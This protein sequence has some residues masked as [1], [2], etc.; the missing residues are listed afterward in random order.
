MIAPV[1]SGDHDVRRAGDRLRSASTTDCAWLMKPGLP[2]VGRRS[3]TPAVAGQLSAT[4]APAGPRCRGSARRTGPARP[5]R[6]RPGR[7][8]TISELHGEHPAGQRPP[9]QPHAS[10]HLAV[11]ASIMPASAGSATWREHNEHNGV[12][13][14]NGDTAIRRPRT[15]T[16]HGPPARDQGDSRAKHGPGS[17]V[18]R[19]P[20]ARRRWPPACGV[21]ADDD[22]GRRRPT[23]AGHG[24][25][26][27]GA[28]L[29][30]QRLRHH[31]P[32]RGQGDA[33]RQAHR[34]ASRCSTSP[35]PAA[36][37][38][39]SGSST[40]RAT[41]TSSC[42]WASA[43]SAAVYTNKS[44]ATL[45]RHHPDRPAH[46]GGRGDR[47]A[48][49]L[50]V[51]RPRPAGRRLEGRP[52]QG[53]GR[54]RAP[55]PGGPD[56]LTPML[57]AK[58]VGVDAEGRQLR[59]LR[60]RRR[61]ARRRCSASKV[62]FAATGVGEVAEQAKA[63]DVQILAVTSA[64]ARSRASTRRRSR[65]R[66]RPGVHQL[67]RHRRPARAVD[68]KRGSSS[69]G[70]ARPSMH[71]SDG[72]E[73]DAGRQG[74]DRRVPDRRRVRGVPD[75]GERAGRR[76]AAGAGLLA[77]EH[78]DHDAPLEQGRSELGV[79]LLL[80][81]PRRLVRGRRA[82]ARHGR[83]TPAGPGRPAGRC[84]WWSGAAAGRCAVLL[85]RRRPARRAR[86]AGGRRGRR[87][88]APAA[89]GARCGLL[90]GAFVANA[91]LIE[92]LGWPISGAVLFFGAAYALGSR[93]L[94]PRR[95]DR[96][97]AVASAPGTCSTL[98]LG[99]DLPGGLL[100]GIL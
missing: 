83:S 30:R 46:R 70:A 88:G 67:A 14:R 5:R 21:S 66:R 57:L 81:A 15:L 100:K 89:T 65:S 29:P 69:I 43:S 71:D 82:P 41:T 4:A 61:A 54:R 73:G 74:L 62:A 48:E 92:R 64:R 80:G 18:R 36:P 49:G 6:R 55:T 68:A 47:R 90:A 27:P 87:P 59:R 37:S 79:A 94:D 31:R 9:G 3:R 42:R 44:K 25:A 1:R 95:A 34:H 32:R 63:G 84:R 91:L 16:A 10:R 26:H 86:R 96:R 53:A 35:A 39:C 23:A 2:V 40:R 33:G 58:A 17:P 98:G 60:R 78:L 99:I 72:V 13:A 19:R 22:A 93:H 28:Q 20:G 8:S 11:T 52:G 97:R 45:Q 51:H 56:H 77:C 12:C 85:G 24:P 75:R 38:A 50:A 7:R 76:R